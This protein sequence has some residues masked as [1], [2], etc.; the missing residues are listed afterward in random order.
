MMKSKK[1]GGYSPKYGAGFPSESLP[2]MNVWKIVKKTLAF[3]G[4]R[5]FLRISSGSTRTSA[6]SSNAA[7]EL[8]SLKAWFASVLRSARNRM[9]GRRDGV[10]LK[11]Q[12]VW[13]NFHAI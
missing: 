13:N 6:L 12:R 3:L 11:F 2:V 8:K 1:S 4:T 7:N 5:P 10:R 9:R